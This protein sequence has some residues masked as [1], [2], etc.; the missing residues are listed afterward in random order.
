[1]AHSACNSTV[2]LSDGVDGC[3]EITE[4]IW[5]MLETQ[6]ILPRRLLLLVVIDILKDSVSLDAKSGM[7]LSR[8]WNTTLA[9]NY[10]TSYR[11]RQSWP[12]W[13]I[14]FGRWNFAQIC[15]ELVI[16]HPSHLTKN[17]IVVLFLGRTPT[18]RFH[19][20]PLSLK[21]LT[22]HA[23][24]LSTHSLSLV[25]KSWSSTNLAARMSVTMP[26]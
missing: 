7:L 15:L 16:M 14:Q 26:F 18:D 3:Q 22:E 25:F 17:R 1:M 24:G 11:V 6:T 19:L 8:R 20:G 4:Q 12:A 5:H 23:L 13:P 21:R 2:L 9:E 10:S